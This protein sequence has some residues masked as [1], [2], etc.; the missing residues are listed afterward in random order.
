MCS[1]DSSHLTGKGIAIGR[2]N[3]PIRI[4]RSN[5]LS[6][7]IRSQPRPRIRKKAAASNA[8]MA[9]PMRIVD[10]EGESSCAP[11]GAVSP[12]GFTGAAVSPLVNVSVCRFAN[13]IPPPTATNTTATASAIMNARYRPGL[14]SHDLLVTRAMK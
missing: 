14:P 9:A 11:T 7:R 5:D 2:T 12:P 4:M 6:C 3:V 10:T 13:A 8:T 1:L